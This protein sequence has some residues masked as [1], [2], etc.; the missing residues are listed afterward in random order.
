MDYQALGFW[1]SAANFVWLIAM[2]IDNRSR[3]K[4]T[5][6]NRVEALAREL[7]EAREKDVLRV[8]NLARELSENQ[9]KAVGNVAALAKTQHS[10]QENR[11][12]KLETE[13][14]H[15]IRPHHLDA[16][17]APLYQLVNSANKEIAS[18]SSEVKKM[19]ESQRDLTLI[20]L[21]RGMEK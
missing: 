3:A 5:A 20:I 14:G 21:Q 17:I 12:V 11:I 10:E 7:N 1:L 19:A 6:I 13:I 9:G 15:L 2:Q 16:A 8:E 4:L 18:M